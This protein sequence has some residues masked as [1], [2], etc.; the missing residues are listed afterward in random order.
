MYIIESFSTVIHVYFSFQGTQLRSRTS[1]PTKAVDT[2]ELTKLA[3][4]IDNKIL[5]LRSYSRNQKLRKPRML[6]PKSQPSVS[7]DS[8][9]VAARTRHHLKQIESESSFE[10][11]RVQEVDTKTK[12]K[13]QEFIEEDDD[14]D[15]CIIV[16]E[17]K[18]E[19]YEQEIPYPSTSK[20][21]CNEED[22]DMGKS[23]SGSPVQSEFL[24]GKYIWITL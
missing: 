11:E 18:I 2:K 6:H 12:G 14:D 21:N 19:V 3:S 5:D 20:F 7:Q 16:N 22:E 24:K 15:D 9:C 8:D 17:S 23:N 10:T 4:L 1:S 13:E